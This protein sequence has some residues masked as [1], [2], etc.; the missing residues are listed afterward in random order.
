MSG[1]LYQRLARPL[2]FRLDA[3][4]AHSLTLDAI[5]RAQKFPAADIWLRSMFGP[6]P[7][8][9]AFTWKGLTF[10]SPVGIAAGLD[11]NART[12][13]FF[14]SAGAGAIEVG[15]VTPLPQPGNPRPRVFRVPSDEAVVNR[16]GFP[17]DGV[18]IVATR[19][20]QLRPA[21]IVVGGNL[22]K[23]SA[24][25]IESAAQDYSA[26]LEGL[27][28]WADYFV[29]NVSSPNTSGLTSLQAPAALAELLRSV[30]D[31]RAHLAERDGRPDQPKP[32]LV[33]ISSDLG[34]E[35]I[36]DVA[37]VCLSGGVDGII[38]V[39]TSTD[40]TLRTKHSANLVGGLSGRPLFSRALRAVARIRKQ[41]PRDFFVIGVGGISN[42][43]DAWSMIRAGANAIQLY[44]ALIYRGPGLIG[45][46]NRGLAARLRDQRLSAIQAMV[47]TGN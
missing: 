47:G 44:T 29:V 36:D 34:D 14:S 9:L 24:T 13:P 46:I 11:K 37:A 22:G 33:K 39:N 41:V 35:E 30:L 20:S 21:P 23:N 18:S 12:I 3:E 43:D 17:S 6:T 32:I 16:L 40:P 19:L 42:P 7:P 25:P 31:L 45:E 15:T 1:E 5:A 2:L 28:P 27:Y 8:E 26:A 4:F 10:G 38:A